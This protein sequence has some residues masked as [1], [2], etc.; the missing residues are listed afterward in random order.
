MQTV[1][2]TICFLIVLLVSIYAST[3][4]VKTITHPSSNCEQ[5]IT[6]MVRPEALK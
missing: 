2:N 1:I 4:A 6:E 5:T 3:W